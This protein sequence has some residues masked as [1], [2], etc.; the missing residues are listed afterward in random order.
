METIKALGLKWRKLAS[1][2]SPVWVADEADVK[3]GYQPKTVNLKHL[4]N[5]PD[6]I[7]AKCAVLQ[8][9]MLLW[10][11][12]YRRDL[13]KFDGTIRSLLD[14]YELHE[15]S[16]YQKLKPGS[17]RPYNHYL[18][19]LRGHIGSIRVS[20]ITGVDILTWHDLWSEQG[21]HLAAAAMARAV[22]DA[23]ISFGIML[24]FSGCV[25]LSIILRETR[26]KLPSPRSRDA[27][28]NAEQVVSLRRAAHAR[29]EPI[30]ALAYALAFETILR[31]WDVVGQ[32]VPLDTPG[33]SDV[34]D[35]ER[36]EKWN[37][38][39]WEDIGSNLLLEYKPSK[40]ADTTG[41][42]M[43]YP[44]TKA[45]M[46][47]EELAHW[48]TDMRKGPVI[49]SPETGLPY[50]EQNWRRRFNSDRKAAGIASNVW[51]RDLRASG[52]TEG[53]AY[54]VSIDDASMVA[55]HSGTKTTKTIYDRAVLEAADRFADA[56]IQ[57]RERSGNTGGNVR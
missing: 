40:T 5:Q 14:V 36:G 23:A 17:R 33:F 53:R 2:L 39:R 48:P 34:I 56:R 41:K 26:K 21:K 54:N 57:G 45:P 28:V 51:A 3:S 24:R 29:G 50:Q 32:W 19:N 46:V 43:V 7:A 1:G 15:R 42:A 6:M 8:A 9:D 25:E 27:S 47:I 35:A 4:H 12:G 52:I 30:M 16:P 18:R 44:L 10:R 38:L 22:L 31:L 13:L 55:G 11:T 49:V 20:D 37:G